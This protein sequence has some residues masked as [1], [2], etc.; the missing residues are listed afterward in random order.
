MKKSKR[1]AGKQ[2][3][4]ATRNPAPAAA[5][6]AASSSVNRR[7]FL[8]LARNGAIGAGVLGFGGWW[9]YSDV[10]ASIR[11]NDLT[12]IGQ[13]VP[14]V[15][16]IHDPQCPSCAQLQRETRRAVSEF[17]ETE[18]QFV[19]ANIRTQSGRSLADAHGVGHVTLLL[20]DGEGER[21]DVIVGNR[22]SRVLEQ[23][24]RTTFRL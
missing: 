17:D 12:R 24:F 10:Q 13:G 23:V 11:E 15:V 8:S 4:K 19:V 21:V 3:S 7:Q 16:Q 9:V 18:L 6:K 1:S 14:T 5:P 22:S 2:K 20:F